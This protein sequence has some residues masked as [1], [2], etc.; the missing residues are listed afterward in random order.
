MKYKKFRIRNYKA[1]KD[2][3]IELGNQNLIPIIG[4][5]ETGKSSILQA[6]FAFDCYNDKQYNGDFINF[7]YIKNKFENGQNPIIEAEI[8]NINKNELT[9]NAVD[10]IIE[11]KKNN[12][13]QKVYIKMKLVLINQD[14]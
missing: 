13:F 8:E 5:N 7:E 1:I 14:I 3:T 4:L 6:I 9:E 10:Y 11:E 2:L 12:L